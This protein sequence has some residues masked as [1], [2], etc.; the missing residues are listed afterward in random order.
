MKRNI[1]LHNDNGDAQMAV[2]N[3]SNSLPIFEI[4]DIM[5]ENHAYQIEEIDNKD[6]INK[7]KIIDIDKDLTYIASIKNPYTDIVSA[8]Y[9]DEYTGELILTTHP[10]YFILRGTRGDAIELVAYSIGY[11]RESSYADSLSYPYKHTELNL[12]TVNKPD[13]YTKLTLNIHGIKSR[14]TFRYRSSNTNAYY[15]ELNLIPFLKFKKSDVFGD[16]NLP[17]YKFEPLGSYRFIAKYYGYENPEYIYIPL[18][19]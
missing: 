15:K 9:Y 1:L 3:I 17:I 14:K 16:N 12:S 2:L 13:K 5:V 10:D 7:I 11:Y 19:I 8:L 18:V 4:S 6:P